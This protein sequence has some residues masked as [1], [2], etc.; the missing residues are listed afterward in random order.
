[1]IDHDRGLGSRLTSVDSDDIHRVH[2]LDGSAV[3]FSSTR[4]GEEELFVKRFSDQHEERIAT[5]RRGAR[6]ASWTP[7]GRFVL[8]FDHPPEGSGIWMQPM[9]TPGP[10]WPFLNTK[11]IEWSP[12]VSPSGKWIAYAS[13][14][15]G[16]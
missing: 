1:M 9:T 8:F 6:P 10:A 15:T 12:S 14:E 4:T 7:D 13:D 3:A 11:F 5:G 2:A 16:R